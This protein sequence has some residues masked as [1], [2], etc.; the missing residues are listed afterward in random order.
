MSDKPV[1]KP[2]EPNKEEAKK[3][4]KDAKK[5]GESQ[6]AVGGLLNKL[7][8]IV[9]SAGANDLA[10]WFAEKGKD[11][12][13]KKDKAKGDAKPEKSK[14]GAEAKGNYREFPENSCS[15]FC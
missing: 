4:G 14:D 12:K 15:Q 3:E 10:T 8:L 11:K 2:A 13:E 1:E 9:I 6:V 7:F 5:K